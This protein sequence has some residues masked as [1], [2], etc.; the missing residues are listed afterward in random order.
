M[1]AV[2][3]VICALEGTTIT[4]DQLEAT[5]LAKYINQLRRRTK[6][7]QL[8]RRAKSLLKK[9]R[10][11]VGIQQ[12][13]DSQPHIQ[14]QPMTHSSSSQKPMISESDSNIADNDT[15]NAPSTQLGPTTATAHRVIYDLHSNIDSSEPQYHQ[16][17]FSNLIP[18]MNI[19]NS[20]EHMV[21][22]TQRSIEPKKSVTFINEHSSNSVSSL[23]ANVA[24]NQLSQASIVIVS[25]SDENDSVQQKLATSSSLAFPAHYP[26][27]KKSKRIKSVK[28]ELLRIHRLILR[29][30]EVHNI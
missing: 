27:P 6:N 13:N 20:G 16:T 11:M 26:R 18:H 25:D 3:S 2:L 17:N 4:K 30:M 12:T 28:N 9:W 15:I 24:N 23:V 29:S 8:A 1:E 21:K 5:R 19:D 7:D 22:H 10:E 14:V